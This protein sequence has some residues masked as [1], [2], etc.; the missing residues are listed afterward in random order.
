MSSAADNATDATLRAIADALASIEHVR[1]GYLFGSR[2]RGT[3]RPD[4]DLDV[5]IALPRELDDTERGRVKL[6][7]IDELTA[8]LGA[9]GERADVVDLDRAGSAVAFSAIAKGQCVF[10]RDRAD[11]VRLEARIAR[12][13][14][15]ERP[16]REIIRAAALRAAEAMKAGSHG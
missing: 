5:A 3:A 15:D 16:H 6:R 2:A 14:D 8:K 9:L 11:R 4:S 13:Y 10:M 7:F 1:V 12:R